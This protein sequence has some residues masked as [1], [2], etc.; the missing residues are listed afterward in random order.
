MHNWFEILATF[1][2]LILFFTLFPPYAVSGAS[3]AE[4]EWEMDPCQT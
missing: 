4:T 3:A 2:L 1:P